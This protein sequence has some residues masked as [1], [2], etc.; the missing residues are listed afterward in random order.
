MDDFC[1][2]MADFD[3]DLSQFIICISSKIWMSNEKVSHRPYKHE[4]QGCFRGRDNVISA[5]SDAISASKIND[6]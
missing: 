6:D 5:L 2:W 1:T 4:L 3:V